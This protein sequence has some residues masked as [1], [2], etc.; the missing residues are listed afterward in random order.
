MLDPTAS[1]VSGDVFPSSV[2]PGV[3]RE[4]VYDDGYAF[5]AGKVGGTVL[6]LPLPSFPLLAVDSNSARFPG[7]EYYNEQIPI[8]TYAESQ[9]QSYTG[10]NAQDSDTSPP[11]GPVLVLQLS[12]Q[13][14]GP[15][16]DPVGP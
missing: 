6:G 14:E 3:A 4:I 10:V 13:P 16:F 7:A 2:P 15:E 8:R 12:E 9:G 11:G 5:P 1:T